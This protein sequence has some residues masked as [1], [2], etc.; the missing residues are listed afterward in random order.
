M[1]GVGCDVKNLDLDESAGGSSTT[2]DPDAAGETAGTET[3]GSGSDSETG[4]ENIPPSAEAF[5]EARCAAVLDCGC[6]SPG[7][8]WADLAMCEQDVLEVWSERLDASAGLE[9]NMDCW[10][11]QLTYLTGNDCTTA[12]PLSLQPVADAFFC[13]LLEG[14]GEVGEECGLATIGAYLQFDCSP[15]L[16]CEAGRCRT[17]PES[18]DA[19]LEAPGEGGFFSP[20]PGPEGLA[21]VEGVCVPVPSIGELCPAGWC[22]EGAACIEGACVAARP[23]GA[24]CTS[25]FEC[26]SSRCIDEVCAAPMPALCGP[27][28]YE[29]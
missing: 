24:S 17:Q 29:K 15:G 27:Y 22:T 2:D 21:C 9:V 1:T 5:A 8:R 6:I 3:S 10:N 16:A 20:C 25:D 14:T 18:G 12:P 4:L 23:M 26:V 11:A 13:N 19:C 7:D 28:L